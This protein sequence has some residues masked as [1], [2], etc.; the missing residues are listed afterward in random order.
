MKRKIISNTYLKEAESYQIKFYMD[1]EEYYI[2]VKKLIHLTEKFIIKHNII[3]M[4]DGYY[5]LEIIPKIG[6]VAMRLFLNEKKEP[7]EYYFD[8]IKNSG[9]DEQT[10]IPYF[11]DLYLDITLLPNGEVNIIDEDEL[12]EALEEKDITEEDYEL[13]M[14]TKDKLLKEIEKGN[15]PLLEIDYYKYL[16]DF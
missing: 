15:N 10:K 13:V 6:H 16:G 9:I 4:D 3:A 7:V 1:E 5:V 12:E 11:N 2:A 14:Q 8:I